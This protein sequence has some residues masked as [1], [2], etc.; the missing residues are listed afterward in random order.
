MNVCLPPLRERKEDIESL[1]QYFIETLNEEY[2]RNVL[3]AAPE[4]LAYLTRYD[5]P[6]NV[7]ELRNCIERLMMLEQ[8][9]ILSAEHLSAGILQ[10]GAPLQAEA[11][12]GITSDFAG[13]HILLPA[14][15]I[16]LEELEKLLIQFALKKSG[17]NQTKAAKFLK[18][19][20]DT[21]RYRMKKFGL[22]D[23]GKEEEP[24]AY[25]SIAADTGSRSP[26]P[27]GFDWA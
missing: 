10:S 22:S 6:G 11:P 20:R 23:T 21:L 3:G 16:S 27:E 1:V 24:E 19:S 25:C 18:T 13:E 15:G 17:G 2:G 4:T 26:R 12:G 14:T 7:R 9:K 8:E 5:W